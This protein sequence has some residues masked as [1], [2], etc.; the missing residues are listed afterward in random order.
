MDFYTGYKD[1]LLS[2][3]KLSRR[4]VLDTMENNSGS[5]EDMNLFYDLT[6]KNRMTEYVFNEHTRARHMLLKAGLDSGQ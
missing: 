3:T 2:D 4:N 5:E 6:F 1:R